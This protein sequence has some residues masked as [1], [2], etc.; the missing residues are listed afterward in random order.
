MLLP[1]VSTSVITVARGKAAAAAA[2]ESMRRTSS[3]ATSSTTSLL[4]SSLKSKIQQRHNPLRSHQN[5]SLSTSSNF[6]KNKRLIQLHGGG[7][8]RRVRYNLPNA[9]VTARKR[10]GGGFGS[11][12]SSSS[13]SGEIPTYFYWIGG[14]SSVYPIVR[15]Y[16][17]CDYI[18]GS[19][20]GCPKWSLHLFFLSTYLLHFSL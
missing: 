3:P 14:T 4:F 6:N 19:H 15:F 7:G 5:L 10:R 2:S 9:S 17:Y 12:S 18:N 1:R 20:P 16:F 8:P 11:S 13:T